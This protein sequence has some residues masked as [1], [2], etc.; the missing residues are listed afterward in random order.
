MKVVIIE[1]E[2]IAGQ[3]LSRM[4]TELRSDFEI[5]AVLQTI[6]KSKEWFAGNPMPDLVFMDIHLADGLSFAI[7]DQVQISCPVIFTTAYDQYALD[8]FETNGIDYLLK[9]I[10]KPRLSKAIDK[11]DQIS[12]RDDRNAADIMRQLMESLHTNQSRGK[13]HFL[14]PHKD[15]LIP[16]AMEN[17]AYVYAEMKTAR[18]VTFDGQNYPLDYS[19]DEL[20]KN[21]DPELFFRVN[22]QYIVSHRAIKDVS[23][24]FVGKLAVNLTVPIDEKI[25]VSKPRVPKFKAWF[26]RDM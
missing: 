14:I 25:V 7:F 1:D 18:A 11:F 17:I 24:W 2:I 4:I 9:P 13:T 10:N 3:T 22:R 12:H 6:R 16:L 20:M 8:A 15:K 19:L 23:I 21:L 26:T 5:V